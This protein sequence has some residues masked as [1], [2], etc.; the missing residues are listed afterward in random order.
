DLGARSLGFGPRNKSEKSSEGVCVVVEQDS[1]EGRRRG[2]N[3]RSPALL[4][5]R[6][7]AALR[8]TAT[9]TEQQ[10]HGYFRV[11]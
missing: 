4:W 6:E 9:R 3:A 2:M 5:V 10:R 7:Q 11:R 1:R 8:V